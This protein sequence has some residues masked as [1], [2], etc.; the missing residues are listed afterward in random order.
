[1][2]GH[3][4][5]GNVQDFKRPLVVVLYNVDYV[6]DVKGSNYVR[7]RVIKVAQKL[8]SEGL[9]VNFAISNMEEFRSELG[10]FGVEHPT[11]DSKYILG[12]GKSDEKFKFE[13]EYSVDAV[14]KFARDLLAGSLEQYLKSEPI[15]TSN[16][17]AVRTVVA[18]NFNDVVNDESKDVLIEFYAPWCGHCKTLAPKFE[19]LAQK[20]NIFNTLCLHFFRNYFNQYLKISLKTRM[21]SW[22]LKWTQLQMMSQHH[23]TSKGKD[24]Y[25]EI[26]N[27]PKNTWRSKLKKNRFPTLFFAPKNSKNSP[28]KYE[29]GREVDDFIKYLAKEASSPLNGYDRNGK[30][31]KKSEL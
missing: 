31:L 20:V 11:P 10:E 9:S 2:V 7:N 26:L 30:K 14:E 8:K 6:K 5:Q 17:E 24:L 1:M 28:R 22:L 12:R 19:E 18:R 3:R 13:G 16:T 21:E 25:P 4:T 23:M 15:P 29:G 27:F